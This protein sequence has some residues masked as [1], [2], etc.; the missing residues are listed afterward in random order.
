MLYR[1]PKADQTETEIEG[2]IDAAC[3]GDAREVNRL[4]RKGHDPNT[5]DEHGF[6]I[7]ALAAVGGHTKA[8][9]VLLR[10]GAD[11]NATDQDG[12]TP[13]RFAAEEGRVDAAAFMLEMGAEPDLANNYGY[14]PLYWATNNGKHAMVRLIKAHLDIRAGIPAREV[15]LHR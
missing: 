4:M 2:L 10:S 11:I 14:S 8:I 1:V 7:L 15:M 9:A 5:R 6:P 3:Y 13:L 12:N